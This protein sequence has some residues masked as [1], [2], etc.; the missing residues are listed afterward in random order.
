MPPADAFLRIDR[1]HR[2]LKWRSVW[3]KTLLPEALQ[4]REV[5]SPRKP[6]TEIAF[7]GGF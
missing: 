5:P 3:P 6:V 2:L 4:A 7:E 1:G